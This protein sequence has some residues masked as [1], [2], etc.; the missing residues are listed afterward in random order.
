MLIPNVSG[1]KYKNLGR[2]LGQVISMELSLRDIS[3]FVFREPSKI[4]REIN[5]NALMD[6]WLSNNPAERI[7]E[8]RLQIYDYINNSICSQEP[9]DYLEFGVAQG[10]SINY[11]SKINTNK[12]SR[13]FGFDTF[14]GLHEPFDRI[15]YTDPV[16]TFSNNG[17]VPNLCDRRVQFIKGLFQDSLLCFLDEFIPENRLIVHNDSDLYTSSLYLLT[18]L[19]RLFKPGSICVFDEFFCSSHE[20]Q[21]FYD[22]TTS[23]RRK[24]SVLAATINSG[25]RYT[26]VVIEF[27]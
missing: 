18:S 10:D 16:G 4:L 24:Y 8:N 17:E 21:A 23:F 7:F 19:D 22:Y 1:W 15:R 27:K 3:S 9:I 14:E 2:I 20:F 5:S 25:A 11:W 26:Q 12:K 13:F 6:K